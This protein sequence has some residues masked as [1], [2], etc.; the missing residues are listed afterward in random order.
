[1]L[2]GPSPLD[3]GCEVFHLL[4]VSLWTAPSWDMMRGTITTFETFFS[5]VSRFAVYRNLQSVSLKGPF[6]LSVDVIFT[7]TTTFLH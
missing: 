2:F 6:I 1:M 7:S 5:L 4:M 3:V